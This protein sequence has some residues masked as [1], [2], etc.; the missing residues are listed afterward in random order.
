[1]QRCLDLFRPQM[2]RES[3]PGAPGEALCRLLV[4]MN[5]AAADHEV[6]VVL[7]SNPRVERSLVERLSADPS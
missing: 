5:D 4:Q 3:H 6:L 2:W 1:M 7:V